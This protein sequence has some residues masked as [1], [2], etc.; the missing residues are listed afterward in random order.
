MKRT[1]SKSPH[2]LTRDAERLITLSTGLSVSGSRAEDR[3]WEAEISALVVKAVDSGND[4]MLDAALDHTFKSNPIAHDVL[5]ELIEAAAESTQLNADGTNWDVLLLALPMVAWSRYAIPSGPVPQEINDA[6]ITHL[7]AHVLATDA[8]AAMSPYLYS[9]DQMPRDFSNVRKMTV[10]LGDAAIHQTVPRFD[11]SRAPETA[12]LLADSRFLLAAVAVAEGTP[13]FRWQEKAEK[14]TRTDC[15]E[16]WV[17]QGRPNLA[18]LLPGTAFECCLPDAYFHNCRESDRR[19]RP[20]ALRAAIG[21]LEDTL[22]TNPGHLRAII[23]GVGDEMVDEYRIAF[24][25]RGQDEVVHGIVWPLFGR[26][27]DDEVE[28]GK[29]TPREEIE[30]IFKE[31]KIGEVL[32]LSEIYAPEFCEDCG[33]PLF[34]DADKEMVHAELPEEADAAP[35][36]YH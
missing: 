33:A 13:L 1:R 17:A 7:K 19:V 8:R 4:P 15:L 9:I 35:A 36:H 16:R 30:A 2:R 10:K 22:K 34:V 6:I 5:A 18:R 31:C 26:E 21:F 29:P 32:K 25:Q 23:A 12:P 24:T 3:V 20:F 28:A 27:D 11:F 14:L